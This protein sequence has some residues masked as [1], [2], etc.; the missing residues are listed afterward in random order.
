[1]FYSVSNPVN[2]IQL[3]FKIFYIVQESVQTSTMWRA[4]FTFII[5]GAQ[6]FLHFTSNWNDAHIIGILP[7]CH[8][9]L[10][11]QYSNLKTPLMSYA[12]NGE[13][14]SSIIFPQYSI[15]PLSHP[16]VTP[17]SPILAPPSCIPPSP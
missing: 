17:L 15:G 14:K 8:Q 2:L 1:M 4:L 11:I 10:Q 13:T 9:D 7:T 3:N 5:S 16:M 6:P 12:N